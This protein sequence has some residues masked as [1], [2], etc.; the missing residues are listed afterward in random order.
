MSVRKW[1]DKNGRKSWYVS[2]TWPDGKRFRRKMSSRKEAEQLYSRIQVAIH[3]GAWKDFRAELQ[4]EDKYDFTIREFSA[5]Y[6]TE[7]C[8][9]RNRR[10]D[11]KQWETRT[12]NRILGDLKLSEFSRSD[13][14]RYI[15]IRS[16]EVG[17]ATVNRGLAVLKNMFTYALE[18]GCLEN[19][20]LVKF[21]SLPEKPKALRLMTLEEERRL[22]ECVS[23]I[24]PVIGAFTAI[25]GETGMRKGEALVL[26]WDNVDLVHRIVS[27]ERTKSG[28]VRSIPL[29]RF[30]VKAFLSIL[31]VEWCPYV[32]YNS[33]NKARWKNPEDPFK[34]GKIAAGLPWAGFHDLRHFR[35]SQWVMQGMDLRTVQELLGHSSLAMTQR[36]AHLAPAH[37]ADHVD[38]IAAREEANSQKPTS[39]WTQ[40]GRG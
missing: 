8:E 33:R 22:V 28:K 19:H 37:A 4:G 21:R 40:N 36:Y 10:P 24:N 23:R 35:A 38:R 7:Y 6:L 1:Q 9:V 14:Y 20:P 17:P 27:L 11:F 31:R 18:K 30:A 32:F 2:K 15:G 5:M 3:D 29:S 16:R 25:L 34:K 39:T 26:V 12:I 13:A